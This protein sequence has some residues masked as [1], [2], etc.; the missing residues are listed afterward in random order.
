MNFIN[1]SENNYA[2][3]LASAQRAE[4]L[5]SEERIITELVD[6]PVLAFKTEGQMPLQKLE[7][8]MVP[9]KVTKTALPMFDTKLRLS[10]EV[11]KYPTK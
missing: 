10:Q 9:T 3:V 6:E 11:G 4:K 1:P 8:N 2:L 5:F 7:P